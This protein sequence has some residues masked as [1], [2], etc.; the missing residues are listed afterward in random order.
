MPGVSAYPALRVRSAPPLPVA[1]LILGKPVEEAAALLPRLFNLCREAQGTA[2]RA[3]FGLPPNPDWA[4]ALRREII[5]EHVVKLCLKW[6]GLLSM[7][8]LAL[9]RDWQ[10]GG[11]DLRAALFGVAGRMPRTPSEF[12]PI[13]RGGVPCGLRPRVVR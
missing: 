1:Q 13:P 11:P 10:S 7:P 12:R 6:P 5:R 2:A 8:S 9:P 4:E 3:A